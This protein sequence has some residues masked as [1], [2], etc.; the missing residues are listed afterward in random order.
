MALTRH[1][2]WR[3]RRGCERAAKLRSVGEAVAEG[4]G[5]ENML[6]FIDFGRFP[7]WS[8]ASIR[9][10]NALTVRAAPLDEVFA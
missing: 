10:E 7:F 1:Y 5:R 4:P 3:A 2:V 9:S 8:N 6:R